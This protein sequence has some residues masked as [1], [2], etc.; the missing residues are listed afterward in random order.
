ME[1]KDK[2]KK[3]LVRFG[4]VNGLEGALGLCQ[5]ACSSLQSRSV[6]I[7]SVMLT[8][9]F[10]ARGFCQLGAWYVG[11]RLYWFG[12]MHPLQLGVPEVWQ[13]DG[14]GNQTLHRKNS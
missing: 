11:V 5:T 14:C 2:N 12:D 1:Q 9:Q 4:V 7:L 10:E 6:L 3:T 13:L 8:W